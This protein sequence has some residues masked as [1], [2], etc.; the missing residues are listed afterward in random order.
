M[1]TTQANDTQVAF[2]FAPSTQAT[3]HSRFAGVTVTSV[4]SYTFASVHY[5]KSLSLRGDVAF[6]YRATVTVVDIM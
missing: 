5:H 3:D 6:G 2:K 1:A 4:S